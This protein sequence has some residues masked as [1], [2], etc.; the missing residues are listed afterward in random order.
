MLD[1]AKW[2]VM[3]CLLAIGA[4]YII[5]NIEYPPNLWLP[6]YQLFPPYFQVTPPVVWLPQLLVIL[7]FGFSLVIAILFFK[8]AAQ[9]L[10]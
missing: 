9:E 7:T 2:G 5:G 6:F 10:S 3:A 8:M 4:F 1:E